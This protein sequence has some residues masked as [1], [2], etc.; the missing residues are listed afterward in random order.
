MNYCYLILF[1]LLS[2]LLRAQAPAAIPFQAVAKNADGYV[3]TNQSIEV[4]FKIRAMNVSGPIVFEENQNLVTSS[5]GAFSASIGQGN[6]ISGSMN[7]L[8]R[9]DVDYFLQVTMTNN[10]TQ[11][12]LG[13]RQLHP[14]VHAKYAN[15]ERFR[16]SAE[17]DTL[18]KGGN[19][20]IIIPGISV[21][22]N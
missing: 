4:N 11:Y 21:V 7:P 18:F 15:G 16:I 1:S 8:S 6:L 19:K 3:F 12:P 9:N 22:N 2:G 13:I 5:L 17:G 10:G 14:V 20:G